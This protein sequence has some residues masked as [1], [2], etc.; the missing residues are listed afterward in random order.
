VGEHVIRNFAERYPQ[1]WP[2]VTPLPPR[3]G[4]TPD[5]YVPDKSQPEV[6]IVD[7]DGTLAHH[8]RS[9]RSPYDWSRVSEDEIDPLVARLVDMIHA[10]RSDVILVSGRD[11]VCRDAT[12]EWLAKHEIGYL[13]LLMR[14]EGDNRPDHVVKAEIFDQHIRHY[15]NV[16]GV[17]DDRSQV[18]KMWRSMGLKCLQVQNGDF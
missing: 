9:G 1:P 10:D 7:I 17:L 18:V 16:V 3:E 4:T 12:A 15:Y 13:E 14:P 11:A 8:E 6:W 5:A 2:E